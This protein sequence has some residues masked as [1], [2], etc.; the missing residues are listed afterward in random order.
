VSEEVLV[1]Q[2]EKIQASKELHEVEL[3]QVVG[4]ARGQRA[5]SEGAQDPIAQ[6][7][8]LFMAR[9]TQH[10]NRQHQRVVRTEQAFEHD[11]QADGD[12]IGWFEVGH[13]GAADFTRTKS[14][15]CR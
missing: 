4:G 5:K 13:Q 9:K 10:Q 12:E 6:G 3:N 7:L 2:V 15:A 1:G 8:A 14:R 11:Q